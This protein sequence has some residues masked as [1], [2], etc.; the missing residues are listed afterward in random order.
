MSKTVRLNIMMFLQ[1]FVWG[2]FFVTLGS[3]LGDIFSGEEN[4]NQLI[5]G[6][7]A[8]QTWAA[9]FAPLIV[10]F[11]ADRLFNKEH[12]NGVLHL[13]GAGFL[14]WCSTIT[15]PDQ[16]RWIMLCFF[17]CYMPT[18]ALVNAITFQNVDSIENDFPKIRIWGTIGWII[19]GLVVSE[20]I[21]GLAPFP[22]LPGIEDAAKT[23]IPLKLGAIV[24]AI[25]GI[26]SFT[27][28]ASPPQGKGTPFSLILS[29]IHI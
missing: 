10:G 15:T 18:L 8:T 27:L 22:V 29:L 11:V 23:N 25:Y 2:V 28:P 21:F 5:G 9:L 19:A 14:W 16:F 13:A 12:V 3:Y 4:L 26:Y 24:S 6:V 1:F 17:L 20:S 7:Y